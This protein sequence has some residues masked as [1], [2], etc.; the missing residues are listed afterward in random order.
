VHRR[1]DG[2]LDHPGAAG[3]KP[4]NLITPAGEKRLRD[5]LERLWTVERPKVTREVSEA[6]AQGD[7]SENAEYIYGKKRL[8]EI[9]RRV[10]FLAKRL[11]QLVVL[12]PSDRG[13]G[14]VQFGAFVRLESEEGETLEVQ[15]VGVDEFDPKAGRISVES[16][17]GSAILGRSAGEEVRVV[18]PRGPAHFTILEIWYEKSG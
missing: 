2:H 3:L 9:D 11:E 16:P 15:L 10:Q 18:R 1:G 12:R 7:R 17:I 13:D 8:R 14:R 6:A 5:E 4:G